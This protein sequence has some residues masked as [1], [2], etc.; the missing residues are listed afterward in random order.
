[1]KKS[2]APALSRFE[3]PTGRVTDR[4]SPRHR[5]GATGGNARDSVPRRALA[6][7]H[8]KKRGEVVHMKL[9][10]SAAAA[11]SALLWG[12]AVLIVGVANVI[13]PRYG[14]E[15]LRLTASIYPGYQARPKF[16]HVAVGTAY[17]LVDGAVGG[18]LCAWLYNRFLP[19]CETA[20]P[21]SA[22]QRKSVR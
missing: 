1:M 8:L 2:R 3:Q 4:T 15:F 14:R 5:G 20:G 13:Q 9:S 21:N 22:E 12:G 7:T 10:I 17:A 11:A 16:G 6:G 19:E 18:A